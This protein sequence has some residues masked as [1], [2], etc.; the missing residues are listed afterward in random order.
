[1]ISNETNEASSYILNN[2]CKVLIDETAFISQWKYAQSRSGPLTAWTWTCKIGSGSA[3]TGPDPRT[4][5][6][7]REGQDRTP[8]GLTLCHLSQHCFKPPSLYC[9]CI[10]LLLPLT[11]C[12]DVENVVA[13]NYLIILNIPNPLMGKPRETPSMW[14]VMRDSFIVTA[15]QASHSLPNFYL[16]TRPSPTKRQVYASNVGNIIYSGM[17]LELGT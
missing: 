2:I 7:V 11:R 10:F 12:R 9:P 17:K 8:E 1:M 16:H 6:Q 3:F 15:S 5:R 14:C 4:S 13:L